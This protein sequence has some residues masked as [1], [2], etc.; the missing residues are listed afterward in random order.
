[1]KIFSFCLKETVFDSYTF[2]P[3]F[4]VSNRLHIVH[5]EHNAVYSELYPISVAEGL[6]RSLRPNK[7]LAMIYLIASLLS[8]LSG[9]LA[10]P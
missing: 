4:T 2:M 8:I 10:C 9:H 5:I 7:Y 6:S 3:R 1:M